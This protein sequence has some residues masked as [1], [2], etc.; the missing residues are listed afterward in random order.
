MAPGGGKL[1]LGQATIGQN[2]SIYVLNCSKTDPSRKRS[3]TPNRAGP[4]GA[5]A[6]VTAKLCSAQ[7]SRV[8]FA[9]PLA[10]QA[11]GRQR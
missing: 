5:A 8:W 4:V 11:P 3:A 7:V 6:S 2:R 10:S 1:A 9:G